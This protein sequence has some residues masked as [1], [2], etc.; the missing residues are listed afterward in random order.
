MRRV[1]S[2]LA[3]ALLVLAACGEAQVEDTTPEVASSPTEEAPANT[4]AKAPMPSQ[5]PGGE[6]WVNDLE[7][8]D[9]WDDPEGG[10]GDYVETV[11]QVPCSEP[12]DNEVY[13]VFDLPDGPYPGDVEMAAAANQG[14]QEAFDSFVGI[15]YE[16]S[17]LDFIWFAPFGEMEWE[18]YGDREVQC[19][20]FD[21]TTDQLTGSAQD[22][23]R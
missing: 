12:H 5:E 23:A 3:V 7:V 17:S 4:R 8:G 9:C 19:S 20:V 18:K 14:C 22:L 13:Y 1:V 6:V 10:Y 11:A 21:M 2:A 16:E 15:P